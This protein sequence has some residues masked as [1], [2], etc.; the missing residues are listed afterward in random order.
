[1]V[2]GVIYLPEGSC[3]P[4]DPLIGEPPG[5]PGS[6][7]PAE[8]NVLPKLELVEVPTPGTS[9]D[10]G[11]EM[12]PPPPGSADNVAAWGVCPA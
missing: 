9:T 2:G 6:P 5:I 4:I 12:L 10:V 1:M 8:P 3:D 7:R 11:P